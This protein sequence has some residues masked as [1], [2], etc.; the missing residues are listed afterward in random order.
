MSSTQVISIAG[1]LDID[2]AAL[3]NDGI[4][5]VLFDIE[6]TIAPWNTSDV[7]KEIITHVAAANMP[8]ICIVSNISKKHAERVSQIADK[9]GA[10]T[11]CF[12][13]TKKQRKP[14]P[15]MILK[16]L[17]A[18]GVDPEKAVMV[19][20]KLFDVLAAK[21]AGLRTV[22]WVDRLGLQDHWFDRYIYRRLEPILKSRLVSR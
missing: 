1:V 6:G 10:K 8:A 4:E 9:L 12:P 18:C 16:C 13:E 19:G 15:Y 22:Y 11:Y 3:K 2:F 7:S 17:E 14:S 21:R 20:D 5:C